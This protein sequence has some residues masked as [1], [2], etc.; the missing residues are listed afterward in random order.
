MGLASE[1]AGIAPGLASHRALF[2]EM[3]SNWRGRHSTDFPRFTTTFLPC[4][5]AVTIYRLQKP[6]GHGGPFVWASALGQTSE[7][8]IDGLVRTRS[9][10]CRREDSQ[11]LEGHNFIYDGVVV[12]TNQWG[13]HGLDAPQEHRAGPIRRSHGQTEPQALAWRPSRTPSSTPLRYRCLS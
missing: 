6:M 7:T 3:A 10:G 8:S 13:L 5:S 12:S 4:E 9:H 2:C 11:L 1:Q